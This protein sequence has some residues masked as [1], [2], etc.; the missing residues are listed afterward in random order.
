MHILLVS[1]FYH[2]EPVA[3]PHDLAVALVNR[4]HQATV[5]TGIPSYPSGQVYAGYRIQPW[6][7]EIIDG[8]RVLRV[9]HFIN[10]SRSAVRRIVSY[11]SFAVSASLLSTLLV[12]APPDVIWT[13]QIGLPG[14]ITG[15][16]K[17][18]PL[19]HEVQDLWPEW[20]QTAEIG[21]TSW[22]Y[23]ILDGQERMIYQRAQAITTI[24]E[25]FRRTLISKGVPATKIEIIPNW[26]NEH[27]FHPVLRDKALAAQEGLAGRFNVIYSGNIGTAQGLGIMIDAAELLRDVPEVQFVIIGDGVERERLAQRAA[28]KDLGN[29]RFLGSRSP[30]QMANYLALADVLLVHL[31]RDPVYEITI[32]SKTYA[33]LAS[34]RPILM[35]TAGD[36]A[37]LVQELGAGVVVPPE[38]PAAL[39]G[40]V[41]RL[42]AM[43]AAEREAYG[44]RGRQAFTQHFTRQ[45]LVARYE[46]LFARVSRS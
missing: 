27:N 41:R 33:Y 5:V 18:V 3:K 35:A 42:Y 39:A 16:L 8:V 26:A 32:P 1:L 24:S 14:V 45:V 46:A 2:P 37:H 22:L 31:K 28:E 30:E 17:R 40:A 21:L 15:A 23:K 10:R 6:Q 43:P 11:T 7:W 19:V 44:E 13:Y 36:S 38:D 20:G 25:G 29:V 12:T 4:G 9:P 34:G